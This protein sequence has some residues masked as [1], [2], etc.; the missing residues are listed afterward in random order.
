MVKTTKPTRASLKKA[1]ELL[2]DAN[3][4]DLA[5]PVKLMN[6]VQKTDTLKYMKEMGKAIE[7]GILMNQEHI[8]TVQRN[9]I[10]FQEYF[11]HIDSMLRE[12]TKQIKH[13]DNQ[14]QILIKKVYYEPEN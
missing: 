1:K 4:S 5:N 12:Q 3:L 11:K 2:K 9:Q 6:D 7:D 13:L 14:I 10:A 8:L